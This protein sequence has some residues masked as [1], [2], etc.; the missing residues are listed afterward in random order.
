M[1]QL[2]IFSSAKREGKLSALGDN[3]EKL[4][5]MVNWEIFRSMLVKAVTVEDPK[6][7]GGRRRF[8]V[9]MMFKI[10]VLARLFNLSDDQTEYQ[11]N[12]RISFMRFLG[13][14]LSSTVPDAKTIWLFRERLKNAEIMDDLFAQFNAQLEQKGLITREGTIVDATFVEAP[15]QRNHR[16]ENQAIKAGQVPEEWRKPENS[17]KLAQKDTDARWTKKNNQTYYG[18]KDHVKADAKSKLITNYSVTHAAVNDNQ[19]FVDLLRENDGLLYGDCAY[20]GEKFVEQFPEGVTNMI[21]EKAEKNRPL[22]EAQKASNRE[23]S[24]IRCRIEH[25]FGYMTGAMHGIT[26]RSIGLARAK[27]NVGMLNLVYNLCRFTFLMRLKKAEAAK[28]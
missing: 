14:G 7:P 22:T 5:E 9:V 28:G 6:G 16:E 2:S 3:L 17:H 4:N 1:E 13:L 27:F 12:D 11:I 25:I 20:V 24:R 19:E 8:D 18:Y 23:K 15:K 21:H 10:L 26:V